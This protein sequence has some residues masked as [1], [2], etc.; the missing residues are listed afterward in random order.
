LKK[1]K[2]KTDNICVKS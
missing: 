2:K 1:N